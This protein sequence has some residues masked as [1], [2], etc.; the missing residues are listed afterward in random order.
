MPPW[1]VFGDAEN[2]ALKRHVE[3]PPVVLS[4]KNLLRCTLLDMF[5]NFT[6]RS[7]LQWFPFQM[8]GIGR[9]L[10]LL[11]ICAG[12]LAANLLANRTSAL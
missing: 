11:A 12:F 1:C 7:P 2:S 8:A 5:N 4:P 6:M 10:Y 3:Y 9:L